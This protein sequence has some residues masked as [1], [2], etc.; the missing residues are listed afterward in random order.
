MSKV[1][2][3]VILDPS[4]YL[5]GV[6]Q[7]QQFSQTEMKRVANEFNQAAGGIFDFGEQVK[8]TATESNKYLDD[9]AKGFKSKFAGLSIAGLGA[10][11]AATAIQ[12]GKEGINLGGQV[13]RIATR[14]GL[15][16]LQKNDLKNAIL[17]VSS[18]TGVSDAEVAAASAT[19][20]QFGANPQE[21]VKFAEIIAK[22]SK[23]AEGLD[24][25]QLAASVA[26]D[27]RSRGQEVNAATAKQSIEALLTAA[28]AGYGDVGQALEATSQVDGQAVRRANLS[29]RDLVNLMSAARMSSDAAPE[30]TDS[31]MRSLIKLSD[32]LEGE[33][34]Q[35]VLGSFRGDLKEDGTR[36]FVLG[37]KQLD[38]A[39]KR[40][41]QI[42]DD[43]VQRAVLKDLGMEDNAVEGFLSVVRN[44][45]QFNRQRRR[46]EAD[47]AP[48]DGIF[49]ESTKGFGDRLERGWTGFKNFFKKEDEPRAK[50]EVFN[51]RNEFADIGMSQAEID[52]K[53]KEKGRFGFPTDE[54][55]Q[56]RGLPQGQGD[57]VQTATPPNGE[58]KVKVEIEILN[59]DP[60][61]TAVPKT[62]DLVRDP[63][64]M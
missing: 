33:A 54:D 37:A 28:R 21:S 19:A 27:L 38:E 24:P 7:M 16:E 41:A 10:G 61:F 12:I 18:K 1:E 48:L 11:A 35:G 22:A 50:S 55:V 4:N 9:L 45:D 17:D 58:Q 43:R 49:E 44:R 62:T 32:N 5:K 60:A 47:Q 30:D 15:N 63:R 26:N 46:V 23:T 56:R 53:R 42:G 34:L 57:R 36:E 3:K 59:T 64:G 2:Q 13:N 8:K 25:T 6:R 14:Q 31:A 40:L 39:A 51:P 29:Q 52:A 20:N